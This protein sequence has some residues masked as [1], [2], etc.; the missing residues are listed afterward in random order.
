MRDRI[1]VA[2]AAKRS[3]LTAKQ[4]RGRINSGAIKAEREAVGGKT[5]AWMIDP[6]SLE[7][8]GADVHAGKQETKTSN[9]LRDMLTVAQI[10]R[11]Q[12]QLASGEQKIIDKYAAECKAGA[13]EIT[14]YFIGIV[15]RKLGLTKKQQGIWNKE[16]DKFRAKYETG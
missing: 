6:A 16:I 10:K 3:G 15:K 2:D 13:I 7:P 1:T 14:A 4:I 12:Q 8:V 9:Q 5:A 11:I